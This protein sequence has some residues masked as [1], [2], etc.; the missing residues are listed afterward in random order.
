LPISSTPPFDTALRHRSG[1][2]QDR[3]R[4]GSGQAQYKSLSR[5]QEF[6]DIK[7]FFVFG[8]EVK[9]NKVQGFPTHSFQNLAPIFFVITLKLFIHRDFQ[10][11]QQTL[12]KLCTF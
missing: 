9:T 6:K 11:I 3:L 1:Q 5:S 12:N 10:F 7:E 8:N 2:A 4:T